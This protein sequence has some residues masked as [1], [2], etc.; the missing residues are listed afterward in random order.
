M[1]PWNIVAPNSRAAAL[2]D[3]DRAGPVD[4]LTEL[5]QGVLVECEAA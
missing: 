1:T 5:A 4:A 2:I 3:W